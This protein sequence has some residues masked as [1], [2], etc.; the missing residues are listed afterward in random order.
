MI[1]FKNRKLLKKI[2]VLIMILS[3]IIGYI[4]PLKVEASRYPGLA[5]NAAREGGRRPAPQPTDVD[6]TPINPEPEPQNSGNVNIVES[7]Y[8]GISGKVVEVNGNESD[9]NSIKGTQDTE[10]ARGKNRSI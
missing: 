7:W 10:I 2:I 4:E 6:I 3:A 9:L 5:G 8:R 1:I